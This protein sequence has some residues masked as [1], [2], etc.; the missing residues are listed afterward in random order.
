ML[1]QIHDELIIECP[2]DKAEEV[3]KVL[4]ETMEGAFELSVPIE[5]SVSQ[6]ATWAH[7]K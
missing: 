6:G 7:L 4:V 5:A 1:L 3:K 2:K